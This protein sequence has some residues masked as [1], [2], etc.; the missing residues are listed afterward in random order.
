MNP[1]EEMFSKLKRLL[2]KANERTVDATWRRIGKLLDN[3]PPAECANYIRGAGYA[4]I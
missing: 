3:F 4:S 1:I 2:R